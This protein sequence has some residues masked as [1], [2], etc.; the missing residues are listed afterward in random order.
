[1]TKLVEILAFV[2]LAVGIHLA[3][4]IRL[5]ASGSSAG[6]NG[7]EAM[8][9]LQGAPE[10]MEALVRAWETPPET[11]VAAEAP[12]PVTPPPEEAPVRPVTEES[13]VAM[14]PKMDLAEAQPDSLSVPSFDSEVPPP[15]K[16]EDPEQAEETPPETPDITPVRPVQRPAEQ[17]PEPEP[18]PEPQAK[19]A[20][21]TQKAVAGGNGGVTQRASGAGG[22]AVAGNAGQ[23]KVTDGGGAKQAQLQAVW[24]QQIRARVERRQRFPNGMRGR[25]GTV[26]VRISVDREGNLLGVSVSRSSGE[27]AFDQAAIEAVQRAGRLPKAP[28]GLSDASM[29][30]T[31]PM[32]FS[33]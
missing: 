4:A 10:G 18:E 8:V 26:T 15:P 16:P 20:D 21:R 19:P 23:A 31:L 29:S 30:F 7:G 24:G 33:S 5:P 11:E 1:M 6:G 12:E 22:G 25:S 14:L 2:A 27:Q 17:A 32:N 9:T 13:P 3:L 28:Q